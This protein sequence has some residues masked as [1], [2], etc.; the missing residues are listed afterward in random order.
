[1]TSIKYGITE[2]TYFLDTSKRISYGIAVYSNYEIDGTSC[3]IASV[4]D[5]S[6][7]KSQ[8]MELVDLCNKCSLSISQLPDFVEDFIG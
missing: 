8:V 1:M 6:T 5:I 2:E 4:R 7:E 3:I